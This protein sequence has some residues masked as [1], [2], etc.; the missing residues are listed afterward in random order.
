MML[1]ILIERQKQEALLAE[2]DSDRGS[3]MGDKGLEFGDC[4]ELL[5][6]EVDDGENIQS[7]VH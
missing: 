7:H 4:M 3:E 1:E 5:A 6:D 2:N